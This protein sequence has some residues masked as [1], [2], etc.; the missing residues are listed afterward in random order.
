M[1]D[2]Y[3][4]DFINIVLSAKPYDGSNLDKSKY[5]SSAGDDYFIFLL[6]ERKIFLV[7]LEEKCR[8]DKQYEDI[9]IRKCKSENFPSEGEHI[10]DGGIGSDIFCICESVFYELGENGPEKT[11]I[12]R[13]PV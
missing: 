11:F 8:D 12:A 1:L 3:F 4:D 2:F 13:I 6:D 5:I 10:C 9:C 7:S